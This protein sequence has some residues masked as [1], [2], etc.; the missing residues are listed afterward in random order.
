SVVD[1]STAYTFLSGP[2]TAPVR[3]NPCQTLHYVVNLSEAPA[4]ALGVVQA[5]IAQVS[6]AT[7]IPFV[8]DGTTSELP[9]TTRSAYQPSLYGDRW[10]PILVAW[11][12]PGQTDFLV[13]GASEAGDGGS[14]EILGGSVP[15]YVSG[16]VALNADDSMPLG[17]GDNPS[18][19]TVL[20]HE[21][22]HVMGLGH[23]QST[24]EIM[25]PTISP[26]S[27]SAYGAG[28]LAGLSRLGLGAGC[29]SEPAATALTVR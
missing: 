10:A 13:P 27:P 24:D 14:E 19:T 22:G 6:S 28:D 1:P 15:Q 11:E 3:Y 20:L 23:T 8:Y 5:D 7:G 12:R 26:Q 18:W 17:P 29:L 25:Y 21:M 2:G 4:G 16:E 9:S